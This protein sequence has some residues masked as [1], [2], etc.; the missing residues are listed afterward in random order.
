MRRLLVVLSIL[1]CTPGLPYTPQATKT[2]SA[3]LGLPL[4]VP[5]E[6]MEYVIRLRGLTVGRVQVAVGRAGVIAGHRAVII[7]SRGFSDGLMSMITNLTWELTTTLDLDR[8][9]PIEELEESWLVF[10]G[11]HE[12]EHDKRSWSEADH[13]HNV[14]SVVG[15]LRGW[16]S[17]PGQ[18]ARAEVRIAGGMVDIDVWE[19]GREYLAT[20]KSRAVRYE[21]KARSKFPFAFWLSDDLQRVP[22]LLRT[23]SKW[24]Q[25]DVELLHYEAPPDL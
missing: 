13:D 9:Y 14:H 19:A 25:I 16:H 12:H 11:E 22:L 20:A 17:A 7:R 15:I 8:G 4:G 1:G 21:G 10:N 5:G 23:E 24:G 3:N 18:H 6:S 2:T